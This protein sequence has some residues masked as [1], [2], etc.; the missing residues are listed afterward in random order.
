MGARPNGSDGPVSAVSA[1]P[2]AGEGAQAL[3]A[4]EDGCAEAPLFVEKRFRAALS[5]SEID[6][7]RLDGFGE[8]VMAV[9]ISWRD[10]AHTTYV[11]SAKALPST[12]W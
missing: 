9:V 12:P 7:E 6:E 10:G 8:N 1:S 2:C 3:G 11:C 4:R 5:V